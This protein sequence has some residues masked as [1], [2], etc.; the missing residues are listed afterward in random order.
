MSQGD[1]PDTP[2]RGRRPGIATRAV[3]SGEHQTAPRQ[4][5]SVPIH[6]AAPFVFETADE[7]IEA[8][9]GPL[10]NKPAAERDTLYGRHGNPSVR[11][12]EDKVADLEGAEDAVAFASGMAAIS[13]VLATLL[14]SGDRLL[15]ARELYGG[16]LSWLR[17][18]G[19]RHPEIDIEPCPMADL[20]SRLRDA[21][22]P[23]PR[24]V[25][26]ETPTNPLL[27]CVDLA[28]VSEAARSAG[29][30]V[31]VDNTFATPVL[32]NPLAL[33]AH[34]VV[35]SATKFLAGHSDVIA[36]VAAGAADVLADLRDARDVLGGC[37][38]P[39]AAFLVSRGIRTLALRVERQ[40]ATAARLADVLRAHPRVPR[41]F[42]PGFDL[43]AQRQM[44]SGGA[45]VAFEI[46][47][48]ARA[49]LDRLQIV[50]ILPSLGGVETGAIPPAYTSH[51]GLSPEE[52]ADLGI[53]D[54]LVRLSV[55]I[56]DAD[57]LVGDL[58]T[59]LG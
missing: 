3:H 29:A 25:Y 46:D 57:D 41:V 23:T 43:T 53:G 12:V 51:R 10:R 13:T 54:N 1:P 55:G 15:I 59:A 39:H 6:L 52:R 9:R 56:E 27:T 42:Y 2:P 17:W 21:S 33:G 20:V 58:E 5:P 50:Q 48:D 45:M 44:R 14:Q 49:F 26:L 28:A 18:L 40:S 38:D 36:G 7:L 37:L 47:G 16:T 24:V 30:V 19:S 4:G 32:Q 8:Y 11:A 31:V 35:H 34:V 22:R